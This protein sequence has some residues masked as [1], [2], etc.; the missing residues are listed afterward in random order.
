MICC[1]MS[2]EERALRNLNYKRTVIKYQLLMI[3]SKITVFGK[4][5]IILH[6]K[7]LNHI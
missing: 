6:D 1:S 3:M 7:S 5:I 4:S 2:S